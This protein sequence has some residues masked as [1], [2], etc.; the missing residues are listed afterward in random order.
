MSSWFASCT[1][2]PFVVKDF[3]SIA[4]TYVLGVECDEPRE[5]RTNNRKGNTYDSALWRQAPIGIPSQAAPPA[6]E[7]TMEMLSPSLSAVASFCR[8]RM[9]S[10]LT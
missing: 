3:D 7:G 6:I 9:S 10:S 1:F 4:G 2:V 8:Y 5:S